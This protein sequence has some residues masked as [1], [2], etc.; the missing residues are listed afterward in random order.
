MGLV[1]V[2]RQAAGVPHQGLGQQ[3]PQLAGLFHVAVFPVGDV[4]DSRLLVP[5]LPRG[6]H[7]FTVDF[8]ILVCKRHLPHSLSA[9]GGK[10]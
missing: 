1:A 7:P 2:L 6:R 8:N 3:L 5:R 10:F 4:P 9:G